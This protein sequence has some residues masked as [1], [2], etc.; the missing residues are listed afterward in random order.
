MVTSNGDGT[1]PSAFDRVQASLK[2]L[3]VFFWIFAAHQYLKRDFAIFQRFEIRR[4]TECIS[5]SLGHM[6]MTKTNPSSLL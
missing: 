1:H 6:P 5:M 2:K 4:W 3:S